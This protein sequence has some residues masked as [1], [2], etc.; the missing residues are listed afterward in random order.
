MTHRFTYSPGAATAVCVGDW[1]V[2]IGLAPTHQAAARL[3]GLLL[4][5]PSMGQVTDLLAETYGDYSDVAVIHAVDPVHTFLWGSVGAETTTGASLSGTPVGTEHRLSGLVGAWLG[6][7]PVASGGMLP[8]GQGVFLA[9]RLETT[10][11]PTAPAAPAAPLAPLIAGPA[12][13]G[14]PPDLAVALGQAPPYP[15]PRPDLSLGAAGPPAPGA[16]SRYG[17]P[18]QLP[19]AQPPLPQ[20]LVSPHPLPQPPVL[21]PRPTAVPP[22]GNPPPPGPGRPLMPAFSP[23]GPATEELPEG[24]YIPTAP[25]PMGPD[26]HR[27][28]ALE[29]DYTM[30]PRMAVARVCPSG[31]TNPA[32][33]DACRTCGRPLVGPPIDVQPSLGRLVLSTGG[34]ITLDHDAIIGRHPQLPPGFPGVPPE[35]VAIDDPSK[36]VSNRHLHVRVDQWR[37][38]VRDLGSTNGTEIIR[39][40][41]PPMA[42]A[43]GQDT[44]IEPGTRVVLAGVVTVTYEASGS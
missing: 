8:A 34:S 4:G 3:Y 41:W 14:P 7:T 12:V 15:G 33:L 19:P 22:Y 16:P 13:A 42:L 9:G 21:D 10:P 39:P 25:P 11:V 28:G 43:P 1:A 35:L 37:V 32:Y 24:T 23:G 44:D 20:Q 36:D 2:L 5:S 29:L 40:G 26:D 18:P 17:P 30:S 6:T 31:H 38:I 27:P